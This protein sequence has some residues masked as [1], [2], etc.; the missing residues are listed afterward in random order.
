M[1]YQ[2]C[3]DYLDH[4]ILSTGKA[5]R[6]VEMQAGP[7]GG[8]VEWLSAMAR[9]TFRFDFVFLPPI[10]SDSCCSM[11]HLYGGVGAV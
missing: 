7:W 9:I 6:N 4:H 5:S 2:R 3:L 10:I 8:L 1:F 11:E